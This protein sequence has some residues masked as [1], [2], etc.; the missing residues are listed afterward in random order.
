[1]CV[2]DALS[3]CDVFVVG[4]YHAPPPPK[5][6]HTLQLRQRDVQRVGDAGN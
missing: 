1:M 5:P 4:V 3:A 6:H 2:R